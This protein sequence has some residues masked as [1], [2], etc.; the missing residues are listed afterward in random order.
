MDEALLRRHLAQAER[1]VAEGEGRLAQHRA[2]IRKL[3]RDGNGTRAA[4]L[5]FRSLE[6]IQ[7]LHVADRDRIRVELERAARSSLAPQQRSFVKRNR[8]SPSI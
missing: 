6:E 7:A 8:P 2:L 4:R 5:F 1:Q 3:K